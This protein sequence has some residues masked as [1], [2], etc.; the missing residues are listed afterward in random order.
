MARGISKILKKKGHQ[1]YTARID[2]A[3]ALANCDLTGPTL[4]VP[5][6]KINMMDVAIVARH[7]GE[8]D[9]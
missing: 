5:D 7:F 1:E 4:G 9:P 6:G 8:T 2:K 3:R